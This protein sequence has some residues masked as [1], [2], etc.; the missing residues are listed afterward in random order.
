MA[1][2]DSGDAGV[3]NPDFPAEVHHF[4]AGDGDLRRVSNNHVTDSEII[5]DQVNLFRRDRVRK[6]EFPEPQ[7]TVLVEQE[8]GLGV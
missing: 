2:I 5:Q 7:R 1:A 6:R 8:N 4:F 3:D